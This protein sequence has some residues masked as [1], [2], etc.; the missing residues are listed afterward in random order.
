M[1]VRRFLTILLLTLCLCCLTGTA[2][3]APA[4]ESADNNALTPEGNL[5]LVDDLFS[6]GK[7]FITVTTRGGDYYYI[8]IDRDASGAETVHFLNQVDESD[9]AALLKDKVSAPSCSC[10]ERCEVG[11]INTTCELCAVDRTACVG[12]EKQTAPEPPPTTAPE[13]TPE[14]ESKGY[15]SVIAVIVLT[16]LLAGGGVVYV[17][18][19]RKKPTPAPEYSEEEGDMEDENIEEDDDTEEDQ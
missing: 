8:I 2:L 13:P 18:K 7:Q 9:L 16:L 5:T 10:T 6:N 12:Q 14:P 1:K 3:A 4:E 11:N 17:L 15:G 19:R